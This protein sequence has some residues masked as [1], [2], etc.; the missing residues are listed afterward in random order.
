MLILH[1]LRRMKW[2]GSRGS[3]LGLL[4][5]LVAAQACR[6]DVAVE[7]TMGGSTPFVL[8]IPEWV[9]AGN[10]IPYLPNN[11]PLTVEAVELG[12]MLFYDK[13]LSNDRSLSCASCHQQEHA[14]SDPRP[15]SIG[16][17]GSV[18]GRNAMA[19]VNMA[20]D[21]S[22]FWDGRSVSLE[23]QALLP[24]VDHA[25]MRNTWPVVVQR[26]QADDRYPP[27]F[28]K[29]FGSATID[30]MRVVK[31]IA[32]FERTLLSFNSRYDRFEYGGD[33]LALTPQEIRGKELFFR[34]AHCADCHTGPLLADHALR[35]NGLDL[36]HTDLGLGAVSGNAAQNGRFK[37]TT[38]RNIAVTAPYMHD[39]RFATLEE[40]VDFY[41]DDVQLDSP[42][43][44][45]HMLPWMIGQVNLSAQD[46]SDL[47]A[48]LR[49][50]TDHGFLT[51][52]AFSD[53]H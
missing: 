41:A 9:T 48:F 25:E 13:A 24:V 20:W 31:A 50:L 3:V 6:R 35:N 23:D 26:L 40:V 17:D 37:T 18:G 15:F 44:D 47:V 12:R 19:I 38:L 8:N 27:R 21:N 36:V 49:S 32:Q 4:I 51:D 1:H 7:P 22:F 39:S 2:F 42:F 33:S 29:V 16:T 52:P 45:N 30:S 28:L 34:G 14:F 10:H 11:V 5:I 46:R 53:P 43:L